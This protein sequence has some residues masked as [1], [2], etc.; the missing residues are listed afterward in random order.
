[1]LDQVMEKCLEAR[2]KWF[3]ILTQL[4]TLGQNN[5]LPGGPAAAE[6]A[7]FLGGNIEMETLGHRNWH[8][9]TSPK[10]EGHDV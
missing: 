5:R 8:C 1:M 2:K 3:K 4:E 7:G 6:T 9:P 10:V